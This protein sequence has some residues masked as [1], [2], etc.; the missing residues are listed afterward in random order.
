MDSETFEVFDA[1]QIEDE[2]QDK[3]VQGSDV[4]YWKVMDRTIIVRIK[5]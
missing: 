5:N 1:Q 3:V 4:E 2:I